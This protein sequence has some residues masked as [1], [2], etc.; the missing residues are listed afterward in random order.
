MSNNEVWEDDKQ[1]SRSPEPEGKAETKELIKEA[2]ARK[3]KPGRPRGRP[4]RKY[5]RDLVLNDSDERVLSFLCA[6]MNKE[7]VADLEGI[8]RRDLYRL[9][10]SKRLAKIKD[11]AENRLQAL[12]E[13]TVMVLHKAL[14]KGD[15]QVALNIAK[16]L[17][18]L[19]QNK[20][21]ENAKVHKTTLERIL[22]RDGNKETQRVIQ[23]KEDEV[24]DDE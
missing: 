8:T 2:K 24:A 3:R 14:L 4:K 18:M 21:N 10:D 13:L 6:G 1:E 16:G 22:E 20:N 9:L 19:K 7:M 17:G 5:Q 23:E 15:T 11:N 12:T